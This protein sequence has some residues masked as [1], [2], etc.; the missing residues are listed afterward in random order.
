MHT[1]GHAVVKLR[2]PILIVSVLLLIPSIFGYMSTRINYDMLDYLPSDMDTVAGQNILKDDFGKGAFSLI[3]TEGMDDAAVGDLTDEIKGVDHVADALSYGAVSN[4]NIPDELVPEDL[5]KDFKDGDAQMIAVF[6]DS[7]TSSDDTMNAVEEIRGLAD[8]QVYVSGMTAFVNDL[9]N[10]AEREEAKY[11][12]L[13]VAVSL[14]VLLLLVDSFFAPVLFLVSIGMAILY[15]LGSNILFGEISYITKALAAILQLAVT[16]DYSIFLWNSY[17]E[18]RETYPDDRAYAMGEAIGD[19]LTA[20]FSSAM[21]ACAGFLAMCFMSYTLGTDLGIVMAKGCVLGLIASITVLPSLLLAFDKPLM[22]T[23]HRSLIPKADR[24]AAFVTKRFGVFV[25]VFLLMLAPALYGFINKPM[26]YDFTNILT[27]SDSSLSEEDTPFHTADQK[28]KEHFDVSTTEM[29]L[30][31]SDL[32]HAEA[33]EM[34]DRIGEVDGV[35][36]ALGYDSLVGGQLPDQMVPGDLKDALKNGGYQLMLVNSEYQPSTDEVNAQIDAI[37]DIIKEYDPDAMLIGEAPAT[38]DLIEVTNHDFLVVDAVA[39]VAILGILFV[40][41][42]SA[43]LPFLLVLVI[44]FAVM[45]NL[46]IPFFTGTEMN[47]IAPVTIS[48]IQLGSTVNY[49]ILLTTRYRKERAGG[50]A[51]VDAI[52]TALAR[53]FPAVVTSG[54]TFFG[55]TI[56]VAI[57]SNIGMI[58]Q[59]TGLM[60]RGAFISTLSVLVILPA[61]F[62]ICDKAIVKTSKGF[63]ASPRKLKEA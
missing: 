60:A 39:I 30:A 44:E 14:V 53:S 18:K 35:V 41:F 61:A 58:S 28:V 1:F 46:G 31:K 38:K 10:I 5:I 16:M 8:D 3:V 59:L 63:S 42:R 25:A 24:L 17:M 12:I 21:T 23:H 37:N 49:A 55:A 6:F 9:K 27:G 11:V 62:M 19:T 48:T 56:A 36:Y 57:Y 4:P 47:F 26:Y 15:N 45:L 33:K 22:A 51:K 52:E 7:G 13:A 43:T 50:R 34:L 40:V 2:I 32:P 29:I 54:L 20:I